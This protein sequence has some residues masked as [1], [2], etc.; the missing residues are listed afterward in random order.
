MSA[1]TK[2]VTFSFLVLT[3]NAVQAQDSP[4]A[5]RGTLS[6]AGTPI[7]EAT[8]FLRSFDDE[9]CAKLF[10]IAKEDR[11]SAGELESCMHDVGSTSPDTAGSYKFAAPRAGWYAVH[12]LWNI[13]K[14]PS[15]SMH[16]FNQGRWTVMYAGHKDS[17][18]RYD[19]MAQDTP[20]YFSAKEDMTRDFDVPVAQQP[21][22]LRGRLSLPAKDWGVA[23]DLPGFAL[24]TVE[25]K[26]DGRRY[27]VAENQSTNLVVSL[28]LEAVKSGARARSCRESLEEKTKN[29]EVK[30]RD[31]RFSRA[32]NADFLRYTVP[33]FRGQPIQQES[34]FTCQFYDNTYID[35]HV[36]K[37]NYSPADEPLLA[38]VVQS[39]HIDKVQRSSMELAAEGS[40]L[41]IQ[42]DYRGAI[43][44]YSQALELEKASP[45][46]EKSLWYVLI[47]NL[48]MSY[49]ITGD[50][51]KAKETFDYGV[52]KD[53]TYPI[54]Y[55]NLACTYA[56]MGEATEAGDYLKK[57]F[58]NKANVLPGE[59]MPDPRKD[60]SFKKLMKI[61]EFRTLVETLAV[62][63]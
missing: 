3:V 4:S 23:L 51:Q 33:E 36:S 10:T 48:G 1:A 19:S 8:I 40:R 43:G 15:P 30:I 24:K 7:T 53:L 63:N 28:T 59:N 34:L 22:P 12:F 58:E 57:A 25:S 29:T 32:G 45:K 26:P 11:K 38:D 55:Y 41:Y 5:I 49:G 37:V 61:K 35:L 42:H 21:K 20:F 60:D 14:K 9:T 47:D 27:M 6:E 17:T 39:M 13:G 31:V 50:L 18:G 52:S 46:L 54:F 16:S 56:E 2:L 44:P 62:S